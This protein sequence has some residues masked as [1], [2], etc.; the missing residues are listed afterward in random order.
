MSLLT[1]LTLL[2]RKIN[3]QGVQHQEAPPLITLRPGSVCGRFATGE[4]VLTATG[5]STS[6]VPY[7]RIDSP[8]TAGNTLIRD[9]IW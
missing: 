5:R 4:V 8:R 9:E 6:P 3:P 1:L 7:I 2:T